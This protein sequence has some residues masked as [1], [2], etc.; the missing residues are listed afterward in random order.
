MP[1][2]VQQKAFK[3]HS[4]RYLV[5]SFPAFKTTWQLSNK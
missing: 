2:I 4:L 5:Y 3:D 1:G